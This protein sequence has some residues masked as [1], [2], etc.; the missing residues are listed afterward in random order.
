MSNENEK[1]QELAQIL[2]K[3]LDDC[4]ELLNDLEIEKNGLEDDYSKTDLLIMRAGIREHTKQE[5]YRMIS[6]FWT[7]RKPT[8]DKISYQCSICLL[9]IE[10]I[11]GTQEQRDEGTRPDY[12]SPC[13]CSGVNK[14]IHIACYRELI[15]RGTNQCGVCK[16]NY[17]SYS[18][19]SY[20]YTA[21]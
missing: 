6:E 7:R 10:P 17:P 9:E 16:M 4:L 12:V 1:N 8:Y 13:A 20:G 19:Y 5:I 15:I 14:Y 21:M 11:H 18:R 3:S 2:E